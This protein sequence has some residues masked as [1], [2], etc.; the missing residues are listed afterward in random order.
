MNKSIYILNLQASD[1]FNHQYKGKWLKKDYNGM[2][3]YSL[4]TIK[5]IEEGMK[6]KTIEKYKKDNQIISDDVINVKFDFGV[7]AIEDDIKKI[8]KSI[9]DHNKDLEDLLN[10]DKPNQQE[11]KNKQKRINNLKSYRKSLKKQQKNNPNNPRFQKMTRQQLRSF[12]Y[13]N[14]IKLF[15]KT[16]KVYKR[17]AS[18]SRKGNVLF[19]NKKLYKNMKKWSRLGLDFSEDK[20]I[21]FA[22]LLAYESL[23]LSSLL[24]N[25]PLIDI[26]TKSILLIDDVKS[27]FKEK[28]NA[29]EKNKDGLLEVNERLETIEND[30]F[31]GQSLINA[32]YIDGLDQEKGSYLLRNHFYKSNAINTNIQQFLKDYA[33]KHKIDFD[34]WYIEDMFGNPIKASNIYYITTPNSLKILKFSNVIGTPKEMYNYWLEHIGSFGICKEEKG[35]KLGTNDEGEILQ[36]T[37]YQFLNTFDLSTQKLKE[38]AKYELDYLDKIKN[39]DETF[40]NHLEKNANEVNANQ[41][42]VDLYRRNKKIVHTKM[43]R[44]MRAATIRNYKKHVKHGHI[45]LIGDYNT[46][47]GN[48]FEM[49]LHSVKALPVNDNGVLDENYMSVLKDNQVHTTMFEDDIE[50]VSWRNPHTSQ[51]NINIIHN[52]RE[53]LI[54]R[55]FNLTDNIVVVNAIKY[56]TLSIYSGA[57]FDSDSICIVK[58]DILKNNAKEF[59]KKY[60]VPINKVES[61]KNTYYPTN[62]NM[63][64]IDN[65]LA[66]DLIGETVNFGQKML[67]YYWHRKHNGATDKELKQIQDQVYIAGV[68]SEISIDK[69]KKLYN[70]NETKVLNSGR[71]KVKTPKH[72][73]LFFEYVKQGGSQKFKYAFYDT[74]MDR[75]IELINDGKNAIARHNIDVS[76]LVEEYDR[77]KTNREQRIKMVSVAEKKKDAIANVYAKGLDKEEQFLALKDIDEKYDRKIKN[78]KIKPETM[79]GTIE[80]VFGKYKGLAGMIFNILYNK[81]Q[82]LFLNSFKEI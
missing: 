66:N 17:S 52:K 78:L 10:E 25:K 27:V 24:P 49:L 63:A 6:T 61:D 26:P 81:N 46:M 58:S 4:E 62:A 34:N 76:E 2:L 8:Q 71:K 68:L 37:S 80:I 44:D 75:L 51:S 30:L 7:N 35:S 79:I 40:I 23:V 82:E 11:I 65:K 57:D 18:K 55:Y 41:M 33:K 38:L 28:V 69:A 73:P 43:F 60:P 9:N 42:Y 19:I 48:P 15:G 39:D 13:T 56:P 14:E 47:V 36:Q 20:E 5:L 67:S 29:V 50:L 45:R 70:I 12:M 31:D 77:E 32:S 59:R 72:F 54:D 53:S 1:I 3:Q 21:E 16:Y 64:D 22:S 74:T